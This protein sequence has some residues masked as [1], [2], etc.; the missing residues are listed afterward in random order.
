MPETVNHSM[1]LY[2]TNCSEVCS[3]IESLENKFSSG[4]DEV[5]NVIVKRT[6]NITVPYITDLINQSSSQGA[7]PDIIINAKVTPVHKK[8]SK[9]DADNYRPTSFFSAHNFTLLRL[10]LPL[11]PFSRLRLIKML[12]HEK[13]PTSGI[14]KIALNFLDPASLEPPTQVTATSHLT[15]LFKCSADS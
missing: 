6:S 13:T 1:F 15:L 14:I 3:T 11:S 7:F 12:F 2:R 5:H 9:T 4:D 8:G 10:R